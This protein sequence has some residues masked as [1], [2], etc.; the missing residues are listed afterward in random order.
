MWALLVSW[1]QY[2]FKRLFHQLN[3]FSKLVKV[4]SSVKQDSNLYNNKQYAGNISFKEIT[5]NK[6]LRN[7]KTVVLAI[8]LHAIRALR[9]FEQREKSTDEKRQSFG[10][11]L[12]LCVQRRLMA[13][14]DKHAMD[15][16]GWC[17]IIPVDSYDLHGNCESTNNCYIQWWFG[18]WQVSQQPSYHIDW[19]GGRLIL[20]KLLGTELDVK[21]YVPL[22]KCIA[23]N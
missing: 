16:L 7:T 2:S 3:Y 10:V 11:G 18:N 20:I 23:V 8:I 13:N 9:K 4:R 1:N 19:H 21:K 14:V 15:F 17:W 22:L 5:K 12:D 6:F